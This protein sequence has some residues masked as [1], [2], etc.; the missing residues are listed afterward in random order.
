MIS[1]HPSTA[2]CIGLSCTVVLGYFVRVD[3]FRISNVA[4][5]KKALKRSRVEC[6]SSFLID[7]VMIVSS[8]EKEKEKR[9]AKKVCN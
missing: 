7:V 4:F 2:G 6:F 9:K 8:T 1:C 3:L 5:Y